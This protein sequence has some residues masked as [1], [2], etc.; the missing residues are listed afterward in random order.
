MGFSHEREEA[1]QNRL[2]RHREKRIGV[3]KKKVLLILL[4]GLSLGLS[5]SPRTSWKILG[6]MTKEWKYLTRQG[7]QR[8]INSLYESK[9]VQAERNPDGTF[10]LVLNDK[11]KDRALTYNLMQMKIKKPAMWDRLWRMVSF[12]I[13]EDERESRDAIREHLLRL[14]FYEIHHSFLVYPFDCAKEIEYITELYDLRKYVRFII[15]NY[16]DNEPVLKDF[17]GIA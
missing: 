2:V 8:A 5:G 9:L 16:I 13:P 10:T 1:V 17:F 14:G 6:E 7:T 4:G 15:A 12:D 3:T 11:G